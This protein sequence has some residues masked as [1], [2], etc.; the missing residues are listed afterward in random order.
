MS[1]IDKIGDSGD[2]PVDA[3]DVLAALAREQSGD[4]RQRQRAVS[5]YLSASDGWRE[6]SP[7]LRGAFAP[8]D[9]GP[10]LDEEK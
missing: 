9:T 7:I 4:S 10:D 3:A 1:R 6:A 2:E 8:G 5:R